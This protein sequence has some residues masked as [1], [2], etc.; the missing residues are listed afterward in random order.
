MTVL[1]NTKTGEKE[2]L[3]S[4]IRSFAKRHR[5]CRMNSPRSSTARSCTKGWILERTW[6]AAMRRWPSLLIKNGISTGSVTSRQWSWMR[7]FWML[8][9]CSL[10]WMSF[11]PEPRNAVNHQITSR[12]FAFHKR[13]TVASSAYTHKAGPFLDP[14]PPLAC[15]VID[16]CCCASEV[17]PTQ[18][19]LVQNMAGSLLARVRLL[20]K[21]E[22]PV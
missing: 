10:I 16:L 11:L 14:A 21:A 6:K 22:R 20:L 3:G 15:S 1:L 5:L 9:Q 2:I 19:S 7:G 4:S 17:Q 13:S 12:T 8:N 18:P